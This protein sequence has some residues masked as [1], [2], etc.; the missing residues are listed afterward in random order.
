M[1]GETWEFIH[2]PDGIPRRNTRSLRGGITQTAPFRWSG[3]TADIE[4]FFQEEIAGLLHGP[5]QP[6][7]PLHALWNLLDQFPL[8]PNPYR[9]ADGSFTAAA[10]RGRLLFDGKAGCGGCHA[11]EFRGGTGAKAWVGTTPE[12]QPLDVPHLVGAYDSPPYLHDGRAATL[13]E[14]F[15]RNDAAH[16]HGKV[17]RLSPQELRD[18]LQYVR[19][20]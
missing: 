11:G 7:E 6:H 4:E 8:P 13:E 10:R 3:H 1:D 5:R 20:L 2:V 18:L 19:E 14:V 15:T 12:G 16:R 17:H 9:A